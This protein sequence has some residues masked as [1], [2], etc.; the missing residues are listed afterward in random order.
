MPTPVNW[1]KPG[2]GSPERLPIS[3]PYTK[4]EQDDMI[5]DIGYLKEY[6]HFNEPSIIKSDETTEDADL[7][8]AESEAL[9]NA[10]LEKLSLL[11]SEE[12]K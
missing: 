11:E 6:T 2:Y 12:G 8:V 5:R 10:A 1:G 9:F 4:S 7:Y 3:H